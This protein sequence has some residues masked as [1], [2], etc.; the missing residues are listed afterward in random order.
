MKGHYNEFSQ[1][2]ENIDNVEVE[3]G[4]QVIDKQYGHWMH[5]WIDLTNNRD[6]QD[7]LDKCGDTSE[8]GKC[9]IPAP[10][11]VLQK[12]RPCLS[13]CCFNITYN[14]AYILLSVPQMFS[15]KYSS[16]GLLYLVS[17]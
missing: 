15:V 11:L 13:Y 1:G 6:Q 12:S 3:V 14:Q 8:G 4:G 7:L 17:G 5:V 10:I 9:W 2:L 16:I